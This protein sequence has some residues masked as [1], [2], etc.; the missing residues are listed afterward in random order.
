VVPL[1]H[2]DVLLDRYP[3]YDGGNPHIIKTAF[4]LAAVSTLWFPTP[5]L[6]IDQAVR[7]DEGLIINVV[8]VVVVVLVNVL[9]VVVVVVLVVFVK[10]HGR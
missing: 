1:R 8:D 4:Y 9:V 6:L 3:D 5:F 7:T 10:S 2:L